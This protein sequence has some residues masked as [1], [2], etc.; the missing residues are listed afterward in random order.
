MFNGSSKIINKVILI[1]SLKN[2]KQIHKNNCS[3]TYISISRIM[4]ITFIISLLNSL[5][6]L[7]FYNLIITLVSLV[8][9][10]CE[11]K[12]K[13]TTFLNVN[14]VLILL[15]IVSLHYRQFV[16]LLIFPLLLF[17]NTAIYYHITLN[18]LDGK[19][20]EYMLQLHV[21]VAV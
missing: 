8:L 21:I 20:M 18:S 5:L 3:N 1:Q 16:I 15:K 14:L 17:E 10:Y 2:I 12:E 13:N 11:A 6:T 4:F 7:L 9:F 19:L